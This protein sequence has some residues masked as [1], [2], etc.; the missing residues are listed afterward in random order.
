MIGLAEGEVEGLA[1]GYQSILLEDTPLQDENGNK[2]F[3]NVTVNFRSGTNDQ[4][5][6]EGFPAVEN[7]IPI[8]VELKSSTPW[9]R[10]FNNLDL[11][12][13]RLRLR[14]GPLRNQDPTTG[15][16]TGYTIEYAVDL[17]TDGGAWSEVLRAKFQI[18]HL[19]IMSVHIVLTYPKPIQAGW[20]VFAESRQIQL[21]NI[22]ATKCML[23]LL[24]K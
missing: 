3:E 1:N 9:V 18:K 20:F 10:S 15:D 23:R 22:S 19:I 13:V 12:A 5:Y 14:W 2:N 16:V 7:E 11:D 21:L 17:Q 24:L 4:E 8:D 6:I